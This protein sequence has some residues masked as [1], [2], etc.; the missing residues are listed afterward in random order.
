VR[1]DD[2]ERQINLIFVGIFVG[3]LAVG[4]LILWLLYGART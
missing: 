3:I 4:A 2:P 1:L